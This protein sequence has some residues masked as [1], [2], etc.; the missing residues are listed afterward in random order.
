MI[1]NWKKGLCAILLGG[2]IS[3]VQGMPA[4]GQEGF[5]LRLIRPT[6][7]SAPAPQGKE[8]HQF[9]TLKFGSL[10]PEGSN[11]SWVR[12]M[13]AEH[14]PLNESPRRKLQGAEYDLVI[15]P[16]QNL[17]LG[18]GLEYARYF[19]RLTFGSPVNAVV[20]LTGKSILYTLKFYYR[21]GMVWA[22]AGLGSGHYFLNYAE[23]GMGIEFPDSALQ[24]FHY[25][26]GLRLHLTNWGGLVLEGGETRAPVT[27]AIR[28]SKPVLELGGAYTSVGIFWDF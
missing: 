24:V 9:F 2:M 4:L 6:G 7:V 22:F 18:F 16:R 1:A 3:L 26:Y 14:G 21:M 23:P 8:Q 20:D 17:G 12:D 25:R 19:K 5:P 11:D 28:P 27:M 15:F 13:E 10:T